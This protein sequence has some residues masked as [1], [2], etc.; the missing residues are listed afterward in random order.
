M[1]KNTAGQSGFTLVELLVV[2]T[3]L[4]LLAG[5]V[6]PK[7]LG[8]LGG[9]K[10]DTALVQIH[11]FEQ[12]LEIYML[13]TGNFPTT[14]QGLEALVRK[15]SDINGWNGPY[16]RRK[17]VPKD[18]WN[19]SYHYRYPGDEADMDIYSYGADGQE[20][21]EGDKADISNWQ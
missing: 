18:P 13:D 10:S 1:N 16:L 8:Q 21:G 7:V 19:K 4:V 15:P 5:V 3:I 17:D 14:G 9:A 11:D 20:G 12:A 2:I 6:G